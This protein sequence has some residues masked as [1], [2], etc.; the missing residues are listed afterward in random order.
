LPEFQIRVVSDPSE[1]RHLWDLLS[2]RASIYDEWDFR[3]CFFRRHPECEL[4]FI[5]AFVRDT[6]V[7]LLPLQ[8]NPEAL[9]EFM[10]SDFMEDNRVFVSPGHERAI[11]QLFE[12][13][14]S[15]ATLRSIIDGGDPYLSGL[16]FDYPKYCCDIRSFATLDDF[17]NGFFRS[18]SKGNLRKKIR[19]VES[20][21]PV[22]LEN[23]IEDIRVLAE[24]SI[25]AFG[26]ESSFIRDPAQKDI[27]EDLCRRFPFFI[28]S[29]RVSG[30]TQAVSLS[31]VHNKTYL[32]L[33]SG[34]SKH[35]VP[36]LGNYLIINNIRTAIENRCET[37]D[38]GRH[39]CNWKE[40]WHL[41][42]IEERIFE[43][44]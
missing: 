42:R 28:H 31:L 6:P 44:P 23:S 21:G 3:W 16:P 43:K 11:P 4:H 17:I 1:A 32:Y 37:F 40:R 29:Y 12:S 26:E 41:T 13:L 8:K 38:A 15:K 25:N 24:H 2:P 27:F 19:S 10:G 14:S 5:T 39:D 36:N 7:A 30:K 35:E 20:L 9:L 22:I 33:L 34:T 18:K